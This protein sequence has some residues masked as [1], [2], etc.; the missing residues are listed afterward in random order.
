MGWGPKGERQEMGVRGLKSQ[1]RDGLD[2][3]GQGAQS[4]DE[5]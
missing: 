5:I 4:V 2:G 1:W 3:P